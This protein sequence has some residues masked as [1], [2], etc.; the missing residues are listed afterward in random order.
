MLPAHCGTGPLYIGDTV[1]GVGR[2]G[3]I[4]PKLPEDS[5]GGGGGPLPGSPAGTYP[6]CPAPA[7][8][9]AF[10]CACALAAALALSLAARTSAAVPY[11]HR[12]LPTI[13]RVLMCVCSVY[14]Q[15][16]LDTVIHIVHNH[17]TQI[18]HLF[19]NNTHRSRMSS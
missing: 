4:G 10:A 8:L 17:K 9:A 19:I 14:L 12:T 16:Q 15:R 3:L 2:T 1:L 13:L 7:A 11:T 6:P 5:P 18:Y